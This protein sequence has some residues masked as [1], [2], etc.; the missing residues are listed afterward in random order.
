MG[1][2]LSWTL[3]IWFLLS[4]PAMAQS[5]ETFLDAGTTSIS[6]GVH[7][8][9]QV[10]NGFMKFGGTG[11]YADDD[12]IA[13]KWGT[14]DFL[15]GSDALVQ[16]LTV[17]AGV[18]GILGDAE[19][20]GRS[21]DVGAVAFAGQVNYRFPRRLIPLPLE[22]F[23]GLAYAPEINC[24]RDSDDFLSINLGLGYRIIPNAAIIVDFTAYD[25]DMESGPGK[26][27]LDD[28]VF[29]VGIVMHF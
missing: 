13:Y 5:W 29:R 26:W 21:G 24:F 12:D 22:V 14:V 9:K 23:G 6:G 3:G 17:E 16:G 4:G 8:K 27:T 18:R 10:T 7:Y 1:K 25:L 20:N 19:E 11:L 28:E 2:W 15:V